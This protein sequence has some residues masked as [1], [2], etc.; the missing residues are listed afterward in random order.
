M[1]REDLGRLARFEEARV[2]NTDLD[3][4]YDVLEK[5]LKQSQKPD[6]IIGRFVVDGFGLLALYVLMFVLCDFT[7]SALTDGPYFGFKWIFFGPYYFFTKAPLL[8]R[9]WR[10]KKFLEDLAAFHNTQVDW[11]NARTCTSIGNSYTAG[12][13]NAEEHHNQPVRDHLGKGLDWILS[14]V[15][16]DG[17]GKFL[18]N[19]TCAQ[20]GTTIAHMCA[21]DRLNAAW[22]CY[23][24]VCQQHGVTHIAPQINY[25]NSSG[26]Y[27]AQTQNWDSVSKDAYSPYYWVYTAIY[28]VGSTI[29]GNDHTPV[30]LNP[31]Y[32]ADNNY[33]Y[34]AGYLFENH[35]FG[36]PP[37][38]IAEGGPDK[39]K[40]YYQQ[41]YTN[42]ELDYWDPV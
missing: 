11:P 22:N 37:W 5:E 24:F 28:D 34:N 13:N 36:V 1:Q 10:S 6:S 4:I 32:D 2:I 3:K 38:W 23:L 9:I 15:L 33:C 25:P 21:S 39:D 7:R 18:T 14:H 42:H 41:H 8:T 40:C 17:I 20:Q 16:G 26:D 30:N 12:C 29:I 27:N 19:S 35:L 31:D